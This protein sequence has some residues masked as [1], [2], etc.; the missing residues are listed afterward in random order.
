MFRISVIPPLFYNGH[1]K[2]LKR[3]YQCA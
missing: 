2:L 1:I 3:F